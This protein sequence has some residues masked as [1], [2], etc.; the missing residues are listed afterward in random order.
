ME[1]L[2]LW[3][4]PARIFARNK[5]AAAVVTKAG[6]A[7]QKDCRAPTVPTRKA[8][9]VTKVSKP[10]VLSKSR[11][12]STQPATATPEPTRLASSPRPLSADEVTWPMELHRVPWPPKK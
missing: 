1:F 3:G 7:D 5:S 8:E 4:W 10:P 12:K 9:P 6:K 11:G 2:E